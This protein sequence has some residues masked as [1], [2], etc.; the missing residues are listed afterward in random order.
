MAPQRPIGGTGYARER[1][2]M[3]RAAREKK[4]GARLGFASRNGPG[5]RD[6]AEGKNQDLK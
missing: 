3:E 4:V 1:E 2:K 6:S 5:F